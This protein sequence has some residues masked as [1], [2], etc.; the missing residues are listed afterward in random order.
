L[1]A[2]A[3]RPSARRRAGEWEENMPQ[4]RHIAFATKDPE[5][6]A[7]FYKEAFGFKEVKRTV[8]GDPLADG[9]FLSDG[10]LNIAILKFKSDQIGRGMDYV[11]LHHFGICVEGVD[12]WADKL[13]AMGA[14][15]VM[16]PVDNG[17]GKQTFE[18]KVKGPDG[19][20]FDVSDRH[21]LG[22][23]PLD[24]KARATEKG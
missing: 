23:A 18:L 6:T 5:A 22:S 10:T 19:V 1:T 12:G 16:D 14:E 17:S 21:W 3:G 4:I 20:V 9:I 13:K 11:G 8:A 15:S 24:T 2:C 7:A